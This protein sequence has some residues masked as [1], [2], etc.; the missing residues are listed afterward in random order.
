MSHENA[1]SMSPAK[2]A[3][4]ELRTLRSRVEQL[5]RAANEP[6]AVVGLGL[7]FPGGAVDPDSFWRL[8]VDGVD[9]V[10]PIPASRWDL[11]RFHA[12]DP[13]TPGTM[14]TRYGAFLED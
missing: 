5:E 10:T 12:D 1:E 4:Y 11:E 8:L 6:I 13:E 14:Y 7:R 9:A 3:L 2:R